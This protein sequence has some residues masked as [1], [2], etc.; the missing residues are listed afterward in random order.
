M[1]TVET[2]NELVGLSLRCIDPVICAIL[3]LSLCCIIPLLS[4]LADHVSAGRCFYHL[5]SPSDELV[6]AMSVFSAFNVAS[7][8]H[9]YRASA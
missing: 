4:K 2:C 8:M 6:V 7:V 9:F 1:R 5:C 3:P